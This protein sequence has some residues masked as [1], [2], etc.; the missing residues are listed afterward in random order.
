ME[1]SSENQALSLVSSLTGIPTDQLT[2]KLWP[3]CNAFRVSQPTRG[4]VRVIVGR[5][6][7]V[8]F[9]GSAMDIPAVELEFN[10][11]TRTDP[12]RFTRMRQHNL[13]AR[14]LAATPPSNDTPATSVTNRTTPAKE[15]TASPDPQNNPKTSPNQPQFGRPPES[16]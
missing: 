5:D 2:V 15:S 1:I 12:S 13:E 6:A 8:M 11:G 14:G 10:K 16:G 7:T 3:Q 9:A 4:G